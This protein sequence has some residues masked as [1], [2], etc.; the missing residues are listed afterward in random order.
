M[1]KNSKTI[2][3]ELKSGVKNYT[4]V[5]KELHPN[6]NIFPVTKE[7]LKEYLNSKLEDKIKHGTLEQYIQHIRA[8]NIEKGHGWD[9]NFNPIIKEAMNNLKA[10]TQRYFPDTPAPSP[11]MGYLSHDNDQWQIPNGILF[12][13]KPTLAEIVGGTETE[14]YNNNQIAEWYTDSEGKLVSPF[15]H[16]ENEEA[17][18]DHSGLAP[19]IA[20]IPEGNLIATDEIVTPSNSND[21]WRSENGKLFSPFIPSK[22]EENARD[23]PNNQFQYYESP[24]DES[25]TTSK[26]DFSDTLTVTIKSRSRVYKRNLVVTE[27][28]TFDKLMFFA[29]GMN[30]PIGKHFAIRDDSGDLEYIPS[31]LVRKAITGVNHATLVVSIEDNGLVDFNNF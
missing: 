20:R 11:Y 13:S 10:M 18:H 8:C 12:P 27:D 2:I 19:I 4:N 9:H 15:W 22:L 25:S 23:T 1:P 14:I 3:K 6:A 30:P 21:Q 29:F 28:T 24:T 31:E 7:H 26:S 16:P 17:T 5:L